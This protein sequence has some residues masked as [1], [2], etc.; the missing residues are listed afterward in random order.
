MRSDERSQ[1]LSAPKTPLH[2]TQI[3]EMHSNPI[4]AVTTHRVF[5]IDGSHDD[6][7]HRDRT[8]SV[9]HGSHGGWAVSADKRTRSLSWRDEGGPDASAPGPLAPLRRFEAASLRVEAQQR[10]RAT[11]ESRV[12][13]RQAGAG[14]RL[15][16]PA[17]P[18]SAGRVPNFAE[19][20][21]RADPWAGFHESRQP[22]GDAIRALKKP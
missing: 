17:S 22:L 5:M 7:E 19:W 11:P 20:A 16:E 14:H 21:K 2:K 8:R 9:P 18:D 13:S 12:L 15:I 10:A 4:P 1:S 6:M 3:R